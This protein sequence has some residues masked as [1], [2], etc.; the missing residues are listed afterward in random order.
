MG[1]F[2]NQI[3]LLFL[4]LGCLVLLNSCKQEEFYW[5]SLKGNWTI[6]SVYKYKTQSGNDTLVSVGNYKSVLFNHGEGGPPVGTDFLIGTVTYSD[7]SLQQ[8]TARMYTR[9]TKSPSYTNLDIRFARLVNPLDSE[10]AMA[11]NYKI[12]LAT[13]DE[14]RFE[15]LLDEYYIYRKKAHEKILLSN[16][17]SASIPVYSLTLTRIK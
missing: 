9:N 5:V 13:Q 4:T 7:N 2:K 11:G 6:K 16:V 8:M 12:V 14:C 1:L 10:F 17:A 3:F 15:C